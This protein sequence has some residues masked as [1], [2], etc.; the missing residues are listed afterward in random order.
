M[1]G[2]HSETR[3]DGKGRSRENKEELRMENKDNQ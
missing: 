1:E 2:D 3:G